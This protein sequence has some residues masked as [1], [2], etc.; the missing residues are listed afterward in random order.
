MIETPEQILAEVFSLPSGSIGSLNL[1]VS[2]DS[3]VLVSDGAIQH[4]YDYLP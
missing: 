1:N 2:T 4:L 3:M